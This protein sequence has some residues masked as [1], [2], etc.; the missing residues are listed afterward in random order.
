MLID[1]MRHSTEDHFRP[2]T[3]IGYY[4]FGGRED[5]FNID[6]YRSEE[7]GENDE[8]DEEAY[9]DDGSYLDNSEGDWDDMPPLSTVSG[10]N[11]FSTRTPLRSTELDVSHFALPHAVIYCPAATERFDCE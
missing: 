4:G 11:L 8:D 3:S 6:N 9:S 1:G 10:D 7:E 5:T 2:E